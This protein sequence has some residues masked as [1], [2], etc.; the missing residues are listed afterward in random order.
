MGE[1][2]L[3]SGS[4]KT[5]LE[6]TKAILDELGKDESLIEY[7]SHRLGHDFRYAIDDSNLRELGWAPQISFEEGLKKTIQW[8]KE[9][10]WWWKSLKEGRPVVDRVAQKSYEH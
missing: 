4:E 9:N 6:V 5:N 8:Y 1:K 2:Y 7:V 10:E 3:I